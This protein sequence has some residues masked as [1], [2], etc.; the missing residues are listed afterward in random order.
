MKPQ[1]IVTEQEHVIC[2]L[3]PN[4]LT[5]DLVRFRL[6]LMHFRREIKRVIDNHVKLD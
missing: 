5:A 4:S 1:T 2:R 6:A 3:A